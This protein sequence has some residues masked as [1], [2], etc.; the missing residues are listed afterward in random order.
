[1]VIF[2]KW[3]R[4]EG[5][6]ILALFPEVDD[7]L[8]HCSSYEHVGQHG[9]ADYNGCIARTKAATPEEY[10]PLK[11]ELEQIGYRLKIRRRYQRR[12]P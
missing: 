6:G 10:W 3:K 12:R 2:R 1:L 5:G 7:T 8:G 4:S 11:L 9:G